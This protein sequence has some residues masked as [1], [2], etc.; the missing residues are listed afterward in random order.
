MTG[1]VRG[2]RVVEFRPVPAVC[3]L[4]H[5]R[6]ELQRSSVEAVLHD[7]RSDRPGALML[8]GA[9]LSGNH[10]VHVDVDRAAVSRARGTALFEAGRPSP[11]VVLLGFHASQELARSRVVLVVSATEGRESKQETKVD[12]SGSKRAHAALTRPAGSGYVLASPS[13]SSQAATLVGTDAARLGA[14]LTVLRRVLLALGAASIANQYAESTGLTREARIARHKR[15]QK[16]ANS[17]T[18]PIE[19]HAVAHHVQVLFA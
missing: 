1:V 19:Q 10:V 11:I 8:S 2:A 14:L 9:E 3:A 15:R 5:H 4:L 12:W 17:R 16:P 18:F 13:R 6:R 7:D